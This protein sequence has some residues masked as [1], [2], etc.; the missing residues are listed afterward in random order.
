[1]T[2]KPKFF[3]LDAMVVSELHAQGIWARFVRTAEIVLP[4][5]IADE[6]HCYTAEDRTVHS[7]HIDRDIAEGR[8]AVLDCDVEDLQATMNKFDKVL[9]ERLHPGEVQAITLLLKWENDPPAFCTADF[10]AIEATCLLGLAGYLVPMERMLASLG[11]SRPVKTQY[12]EATFKRLM[13]RAASSRIQG[14]GL[15]IR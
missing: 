6:A 1:M 2:T 8:I 5:I 15:A 3:L 12:S 9:Q 7:T 4:T 14:R 11:L 10:K 13:D